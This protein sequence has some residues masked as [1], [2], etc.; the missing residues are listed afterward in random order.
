MAKRKKATQRRIRAHHGTSLQK[1]R[2]QDIES[3]VQQLIRRS[4]QQPN[5]Q[6]GKPESR[7]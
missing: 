5:Q 4:K 3:H 6:R 7:P 2:Q 1:Q